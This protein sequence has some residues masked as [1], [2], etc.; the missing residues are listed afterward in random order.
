MSQHHTGQAGT[1][2]DDAVKRLLVL[3]YYF[4]PIGGAGV[5]RPTKFAGHLRE[6]G[7]EPV[8]ITGPGISTG[9]WTPHDASL[10]ADVPGEVQVVRVA[11][12][13]PANSTEW[14]G[15]AD[16]WLRLQSAWDRW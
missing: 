11:A 2:P 13:E 16:R 1:L 12:S 5:Q 3:A 7:Y 4:P 6:F 15:R 8:V 9:R 10:A 14:R